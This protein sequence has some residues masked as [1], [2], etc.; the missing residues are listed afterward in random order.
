VS[1]HPDDHVTALPQSEL[2]A[3]Q[4]LA[5]LSEL[6]IS[7]TDANELTKDAV[8]AIFGL[9]LEQY[10]EDV[11]DYGARLTSD[12]N[13]AISVSNFESSGPT[14][15]LRFFPGASRDDLTMTDICGVDAAAF[16]TQLEQAGFIGRP[17]TDVH[18]LQHYGTKYRRG[19]LQITV[20][21][22]REATEPPE[23]RSHACV[24]TVQIQG[25]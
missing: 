13:V 3:E 22:K 21:T 18:G 25:Q 6:I 20:L 7:T 24:E 15:T 16:G 5:K 4:L 14:V 23:M 11:F 19:S 8:E 2:T 17:A 1:E 9:Q 10:E 12:W